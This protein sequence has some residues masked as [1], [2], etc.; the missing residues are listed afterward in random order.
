M[1]ELPENLPLELSPLAWV[2]GRWQGWGVLVDADAPEAD[3]DAANPEE[4]SPEQYIIQ[5][6]AAQI[7]GDQMRLTTTIFA[8][9]ATEALDMTL[10]AA[11]GLDLLTAGEL[12]FEE[13]GYWK[14][15][16][17]LAVVPAQG[18]EP[19]ELRVSSTDTRGVSIL[20]AGVAMGPRLRL[21][22]DVLARDPN[23][24]QLD[25]ITRMFGLVGGELFWTSESTTGDAD[26]VVELTGRLQRVASANEVGTDR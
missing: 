9:E 8:A 20:W 1:F 18:E 21:I 17:P 23:A 26:P 6:V 10:S 15:A 24:P 5:E 13:T 3:A 7:V 22:S 11:D 25:Q 4:A 14:V 2:L 16:T 12:I 19:R